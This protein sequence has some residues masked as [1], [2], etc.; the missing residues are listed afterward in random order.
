[1]KY[2]GKELRCYTKE[3]L[4]GLC[5]AEGIDVSEMSR[6]E[7][8][9][10]LLALD[11]S[12]DVEI[13]DAVLEEPVSDPVVDEGARLAY[14]RE[15]SRRMGNRVADTYEQELARRRGAGTHLSGED[16]VAMEIARRRKCYGGR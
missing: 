4:S 15:L 13:V 2:V 14:E 10:A 16:A 7:M 8:M 5:V 3:E 6:G 12:D 11:E 1:M 9:K